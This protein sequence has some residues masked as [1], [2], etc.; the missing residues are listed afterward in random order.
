MGDCCR[1]KIPRRVPWRS[2]EKH[3]VFGSDDGNCLGEV[4]ENIVEKGENSGYQNFL[5]CQQCFK[6]AS[7]K[8]ISIILC[9]KPFTKRQN[10][11][12]YQIESIC[13]RWIKMLLE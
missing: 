7:S 5:L 6:R 4:L 8:C 13:R 3:S 1:M 12:R 9:G 2:Y 10:F 11:G